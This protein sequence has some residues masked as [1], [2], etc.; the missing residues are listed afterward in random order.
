MKNRLA[1]QLTFKVGIVILGGM[2]VYAVFQ[3]LAGEAGPLELFIRHLWHT[4]IL[5]LLI[6]GFLLLWL[7]S[8]FLRPV[9]QIVAHANR[10]S[11]G[12]FRRWK[13]SKSSN[14]IDQVTAVMNRMAEHLNFI[15]QTSWRKYAETIEL[16]LQSLH[17]RGDLP[18]QV[19]GE[20]T[21]IRDSL[22][23]M[24]VAILGFVE[25]LA[26]PVDQW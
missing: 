12:D 22:H 15:K 8:T 25:N 26:D 19:Q 7:R 17:E 6:Y 10:L 2:L 16:H 21:D 24:D 3:Y 13:Y 11:Q 14:E 18:L 9:K 5:G 23:K 4:V 20:L 1:R